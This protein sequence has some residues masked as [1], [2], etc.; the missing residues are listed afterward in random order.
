MKIFLTIFKKE[1]IDTIRD[2]RTIITMII[3]PLLLFPILMTVV[4]K[5]SISQRQKAQ[6]KTLNVA[7]V[8]NGNAAAFRDELLR[9][10]DLRVVENV[11]VDSI[12]G[13]IQRD[14]LDAAFVVA[15]DFDRR[16]EANE[17]GSIQL[18]FKAS[19][20]FN[21][22]K[23]RLTDVVQSYE[24]RL[25]AERFKKM[26][27]SET[28][29]KAVS[30]QEHDIASLREK[31]GKAIGGFLP[32]IFVIFC[33]TGAMYPAI[34]LGAGE[35]E[36]GTLETLL[37]A[38]TS[39]FLILLGKF[40]V[41]VLAGVL[42]AGVSMVGLFVSVR[43]AV[44]LP[45]DVM[46]AVLGVLQFDTIVLV[47]SL[48]VPLTVFFAGALLSLSIYAKSFKEAQSIISPMTFVVIIPVAV[49]L[50][51]GVELDTVTALIPVLNV[52]LATKEIIAG[53]VSAGLLVEVYVILFL[54][55]G[56]SLYVASK[57]FDRE[58]TIFRGV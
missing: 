36:R 47:L 46:N 25:L 6:Q 23:R 2:R 9:R 16:V 5:V 31:I 26:K 4:T 32:Y 55:A 11:L 38:P 54:L 51:P 19:D 41:V 20:E 28:I 39:R 58:E 18:Y 21:I 57:W 30:V 52:S 34:D 33:F 7:L 27:L 15:D 48:L 3:V 13:F 45:A 44:D 40:C 43:Q 35:K 29:V 17:S 50:F 1:F 22:A 12:E 56:L 14:S 24:K 10:G 37:T 49:G 42:S 53:T 8:S